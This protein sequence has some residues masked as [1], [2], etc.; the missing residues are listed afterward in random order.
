[1]DTRNADSYLKKPGYEGKKQR[2][3]LNAHIR[4]NVFKSIHLGTFECRDG[5]I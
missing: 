4:E 3:Q 2:K 1:M 5:A